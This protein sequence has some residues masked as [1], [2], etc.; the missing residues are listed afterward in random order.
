MLP[1]NKLGDA[2]IKK[3]KVYK[4]SAHPHEAQKPVVFTGGVRWLAVTDH[5]AGV[6]FEIRIGEFHGGGGIHRFAGA[7]ATGDCCSK[8]KYERRFFHFSAFR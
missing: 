8:D 3:L 6:R 5:G 7:G 2:I 1:H 4:G